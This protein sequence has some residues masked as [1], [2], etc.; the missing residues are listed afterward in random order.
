MV[1]VGIIILSIHQHSPALLPPH[2]L[3]RQSG[4]ADITVVHF[5]DKVKPWHKAAHVRRAHPLEARWS[6]I[7]ET[8][9]PCHAP[10]D[11]DNMAQYVQGAMSSSN[12]A[13]AGRVTAGAPACLSAAPCGA[14]LR[15]GVDRAGNSAALV[16]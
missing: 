12:G 9:P 6:D 13:R 1:A 14:G 2:C 3:H 7:L 5:N 10:D 11:V 15:A 8:V 16:E 4:A